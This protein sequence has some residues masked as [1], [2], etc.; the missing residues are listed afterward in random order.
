M[1][2]ADFTVMSFIVRCA[3]LNI[4]LKCICKDKTDRYIFQTFY[5]FIDDALAP[6]KRIKIIANASTGM[7]L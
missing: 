5:F 1:T 7:D 6:G 2:A 3:L 4:F